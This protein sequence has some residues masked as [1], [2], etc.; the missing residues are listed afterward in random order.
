MAS[1]PPQLEPYLD[2]IPDPAG[3]VSSLSCPFPPCF[4]HNGLKVS[5]AALLDILDGEGVPAEKVSGVPRLFRA[6]SKKMLGT[7]LAYHLGYLYPQALSSALPVLALAPRPGSLVLDLCAAPG[8][9]STHMAQLMNDTGVLVANDRKRS[10]LTALAANTQRQ[11]I[12]NTV[13]TLSHGEHFP[14][15]GTFESVL[16][17]APCSGE[18]RYKTADSGDIMHRRDGRTNLASI[19]KGLLKRAFDL[20]R[21]GGTLVYSTCTLNPMENE[22]VVQFLLGSRDARLVRW[23]PPLPWSPGLTTYMGKDYDRDMALC[24]RFYPHL[25]HSV[26]FFVAK[27]LR[28]RPEA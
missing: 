3:Y 25:V 10:R 13:I 6:Q 24:R 4:R 17:D 22:D 8:T 19:Q 15:A 12:T 1:V 18:G 27:I 7:L 16:V 9:K 21:P 5:E 23:E 28:P 20:L 26:G 11:G 14:L 2:F